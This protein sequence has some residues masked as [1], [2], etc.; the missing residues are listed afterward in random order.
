MCMKFIW[1]HLWAPAWKLAHFFK[2]RV[3]ITY[4]AAN[5]SYSN[6]NT[7]GVRLVWNKNKPYNFSSYWNPFNDDIPFCTF[8]YHPLFFHKGKYIKPEFADS[9]E[10]NDLTLASGDFKF[11]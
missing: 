8:T 4:I 5:L 1:F 3:C 10:T 9:H 6:R 7:K 11:N 2:Y